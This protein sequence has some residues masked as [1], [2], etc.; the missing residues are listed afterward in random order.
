[1]QIPMET[2]DGLDMYS[3]IWIIFEF[4]AN[5]DMKS[6][7]KTKIRPPRGG[8]IKV[9][10][11]A[12]RSPHRPNPLGLTLVRLETIDAAAKRIHISALDLVHGTPV[13]DV[14]PCVPW[15]VPGYKS[16]VLLAVPKWVEN[17]DD[18][19]NV[20]FSQNALQGLNSMVQG[21]RMAPLY[22]DQNGGFEAARRTL[23]EILK[24]DP[25][26]SHKRGTLTENTERSYSL[27]F[28]QTQ[29]QFRVD[30]AG[31]LVLEVFA[32]DFAD[33]SFVDGIPL[34]NT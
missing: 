34:V 16:G 1:M 27:L 20:V 6:S 8:G 10:Q 12:T 13:Y 26:A 32:V 33:S 9:G 7:K 11:L 30:E 17:D 18:V 5:T 22:T 28:G 4:H 23:E 25:R 19:T 21:D 29:V 3:H 15:D 2:L 14:K 31:L 24:Q